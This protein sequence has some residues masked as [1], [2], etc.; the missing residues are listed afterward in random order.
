MGLAMASSFFSLGLRKGLSE[1]VAVYRTAILI[2]LVATFAVAWTVHYW[3][4]SYVFFMFFMGAGIWILDASPEEH[5]P[6]K[7]R[8]VRY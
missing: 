5:A 7:V 3:D 2:S 8:D 4:A 6:P 1:K